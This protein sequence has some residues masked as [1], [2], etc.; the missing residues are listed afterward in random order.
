MNIHIL[1]IKTG[2]KKIKK[3]LAYTKTLRMAL[4]RIEKLKWERPFRAESLEKSSTQVISPL[5]FVGSRSPAVSLYR[6]QRNPVVRLLDIDRQVGKRFRISGAKNRMLTG[7]L[8]N[9]SHPFVRSHSQS[10]LIL[11]QKSSNCFFPLAFLCTA[12]YSCFHFGR[13][14]SCYL[15]VQM[16]IVGCLTNSSRICFHLVINQF[17]LVTLSSFMMLH[18]LRSRL[19]ILCNLPCQCMVGRI[20]QLSTY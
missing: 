15:A 6:Q 17:C 16:I 4:H 3:Q 14:L 20:F 1:N 13:L 10:M 7:N 18:P 2:T 8:M 5:A 19:T 12:R 11:Q 9:V